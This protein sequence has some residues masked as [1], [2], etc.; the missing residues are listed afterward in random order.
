MGSPFLEQPTVGM[1]NS[2]NDDVTKMGPCR[3]AAVGGRGPV[4]LTGG[5]KEILDRRR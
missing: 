1:D 2:S 3:A 4:V 5:A